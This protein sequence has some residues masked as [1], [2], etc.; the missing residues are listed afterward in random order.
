MQQIVNAVNKKVGTLRNAEKIVFDK[1]Y[2]EE[3]LIEANNVILALPSN[4]PRLGVKVASYGYNAPAKKDSKAEITRARLPMPEPAAIDEADRNL[5]WLAR[6]SN[7][8]VRKIV[9]MRVQ[10]RQHTGR[11][12]HGWASIALTVNA[13]VPACKRWYEQGLAEIARSLT[14]PN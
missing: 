5:G 7:P 6:I 2:V 10:H 8:V 1:T 3:R 13:A 4:S 12:I 14:I 11:H 9:S